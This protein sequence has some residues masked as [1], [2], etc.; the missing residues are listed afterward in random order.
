MDFSNAS[1]PLNVLSEIFFNK[2]GIGRVGIVIAR[3]KF[4]RKSYK[5][6]PTLPLIRYLIWL[7]GA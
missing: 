3:T 2:S 5:V 6:M 1:K 7:S 4:L